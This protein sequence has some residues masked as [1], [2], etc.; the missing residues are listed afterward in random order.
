M[1]VMLIPTIAKEYLHREGGGEEKTHLN[2]IDLNAHSS[3]K[4]EQKG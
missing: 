3:Q 1:D 4:A 2:I